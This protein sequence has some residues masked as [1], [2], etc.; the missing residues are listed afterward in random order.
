MDRSAK[1]SMKNTSPC[2]ISV[3]KSTAK[4]HSTEARRRKS[5]IGGYWALGPTPVQKFRFTR[6]WR[7]LTGEINVVALVF[8]ACLLL[9]RVHSLH[10]CVR[11]SGAGSGRRVEE[12]R[13]QEQR[14]LRQ[15]MQEWVGLWLRRQTCTG[16]RKHSIAGP[17]FKGW[18]MRECRAKAAAGLG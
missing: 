14:P 11:Q 2:Q 7:Q 8:R 16:R 3:S 13:Q 6:L 10:K 18:S 4:K 1:L 5:E 15:R 17:P 9:Q 12:R